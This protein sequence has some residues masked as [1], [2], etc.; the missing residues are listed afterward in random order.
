MAHSVLAIANKF[1]RKNDGQPPRLTAMQLQKLCYLA[2]GFTLA[3]LDDPLISDRLEAWNWGPVYPALYDALRK[4]GASPIGELIHRNNWADY[5][6]IRGSI[7]DESL[8][9]QEE[10][11][12]D[13]VWTDY[14]DFDA[15][16]LSALTHED[17][18]P[19][20]RVFKPGTRGIIIP[21]DL[22]KEYFVGLTT[23]R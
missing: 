20:S 3:I 14:G 7:V 18:S 9:D 6:H 10:R 23:H 8:N 1:L 17:G 11:I 15:F 4:E 5:L 12:V 21:D 2:H 19:W 13:K 16:Q 22:I